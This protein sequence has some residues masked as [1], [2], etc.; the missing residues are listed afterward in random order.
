[1][2]LT[3]EGKDVTRK[4]NHNLTFHMNI[5]ANILHKILTNAVIY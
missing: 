2:I 5:Y 1:M 3:K 4:E